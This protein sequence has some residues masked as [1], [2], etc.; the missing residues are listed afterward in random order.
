MR[1]T[2]TR[3]TNSQA[4]D[5]SGNLDVAKELNIYK[6]LSLVLGGEGW[7][8]EKMDMCKSQKLLICP[9]RHQLLFCP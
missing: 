4:D 8:K 9:S 6:D 2:P 1:D 5:V 7:K 3:E